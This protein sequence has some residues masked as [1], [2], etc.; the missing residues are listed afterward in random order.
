[1]SKRLVECLALALQTQHAQG[2]QD[3]RD[4]EVVVVHRNTPIFGA[5]FEVGS[6]YEAKAMGTRRGHGFLQQLCVTGRCNRR[7]SV[8]RCGGCSTIIAVFGVLCIDSQ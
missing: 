3:T 1:M 7:V 6:T 4:A 8:E 2:T 5:L